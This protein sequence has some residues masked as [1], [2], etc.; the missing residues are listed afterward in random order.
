MAGAAGAV[1]AYL[2]FVRPKWRRYVVDIGHHLLNLA[3]GMQP[4]SDLREEVREELA[5]IQNANP[6]VR[7]AFRDALEE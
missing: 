6:Q 3:E 2:F 5:H 7:E 1:V 4:R